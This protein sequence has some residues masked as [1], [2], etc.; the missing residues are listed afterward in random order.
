MSVHHTYRLGAHA[1]IVNSEGC[2]LLLKRTYGDR[3]WGLPGGGVDP[4]E[5]LHQAL[6]REVKEEI[7]IGVT[8]AVLTGFYYHSKINCHVGIFRCS[9]PSEPT[10]TLSPEHSEYKWCPVSELSEVQRIRVMDA[11]AYQGQVISRAF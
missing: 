5:T 9:I 10:I 7:G 4:G 2:V 8:D 3:G 1:V 6:Q 11:L